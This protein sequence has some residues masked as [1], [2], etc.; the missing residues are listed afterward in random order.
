MKVLF[1]RKEYKLPLRTLALVLLFLI[2]F[3]GKKTITVIGKKETLKNKTASTALEE[4]SHAITQT[5]E[6]VAYLSAELSGYE[7]YAAYPQHEAPV[8]FLK[9]TKAIRALWQ[10]EEVKI[11]GGFAL[12][13]H[14]FISL[15][16]SSETQTESG[17]IIYGKLIVTKK[18]KST[19]E[20]HPTKTR[21]AI[22]IGTHYA[23]VDRNASAEL[24]LGSTTG[25]TMNFQLNSTTGDPNHFVCEIDGTL[26]YK[27]NISYFQ[28][29]EGKEQ[30]PCKLFVYFS[31][32]KAQVFMTSHNTDC[33]CEMNASPEGVFIQR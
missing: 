18:D 14:E 10:N 8:Y 22:T 33:G 11:P 26:F 12:T 30:N 9:D 29:K 15:Q 6:L 3:S 24:V 4:T 23:Y 5:V 31:D 16:P 2:F 13:D 17:I 19:A 7:L 20:F 1:I 25:N 28:S 32:K 21:R 27:E